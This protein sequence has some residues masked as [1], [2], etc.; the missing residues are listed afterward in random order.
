MYKQC[1]FSLN[2]I[3]SRIRLHIINLYQD[4]IITKQLIKEKQLNLFKFAFWFCFCED[5]KYKRVSPISI[6]KTIRESKIIY[7]YV[8]IEIY[9]L[10][11]FLKNVLPVVQQ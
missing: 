9:L 6:T 5:G 1:F 11:L 10:I 2:N 3:L 4:K 7:I 8:Y